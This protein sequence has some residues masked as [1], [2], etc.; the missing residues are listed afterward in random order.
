M[1]AVVK[2][3]VAI[4]SVLVVVVAGYSLFLI[5]LDLFGEQTRD[6]GMRMATGVVG[7]AV[8]LVLGLLAAM[9][10]RYLTKTGDAQDGA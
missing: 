10:L 7:L 9:G 1:R 6:T 3:V 8:A 2:V 5:G 4:I